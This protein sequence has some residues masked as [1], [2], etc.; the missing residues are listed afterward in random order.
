MNNTPVSGRS[1]ETRSHPI[2]MNKYL[3]QK[4]QWTMAGNLHN[5]NLSVPLVKC[6][7]SHII[8]PPQ[9]SSLSFR[10]LS[11]SPSR[12]QTTKHRKVISK[13]FLSINVNL[14]SLTNKFIRANP[15]QKKNKKV[16]YYPSIYLN[17]LTETTIN[18]VM[19][20]NH[21]FP[22]E[23]KYPRHRTYD[24][25]VIFCQFTFHRTVW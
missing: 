19:A 7:V 15:F 16:L 9:F 23:T 21:S 8:L 17:K 14:I 18:S 22:I 1:S 12:I 4:V 2:D 10:L 11:H 20:S 3:Y 13:Y 5:R 6:S 24:V 25:F